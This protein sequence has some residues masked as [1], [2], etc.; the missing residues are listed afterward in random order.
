MTATIDSSNDSSN[1]GGAPE[2]LQQAAQWFAVMQSESVTEQE[3]KA[4]Q[5]W[6]SS[7]EQH[8]QAWQKVES[9]SHRFI[10][11]PVAASRAALDSSA[12]SAITRRQAL[13]TFAF[14]F[15]SSGIVWQVARQRHWDAQYRTARGEIRQLD[16]D[17]GSRL[18]LNTASAVD[19][20]FSPTLRQ[21]V[22][23]SGELYI[24][25]A[26][27]TRKRKRPLVVD[28]RFGR[29]QALGTRF[30]V[31]QGEDRTLLSVMQAAVEIRL[32]HN[33]SNVHPQVKRVKSGQQVSFNANTLQP[34]VSLASS[35]SA[36]IKGVIVADNMRLD[37]FINE[38]NRY[39]KGH[40]G[41]HPAVAGLR[42][43]GAYPVNDVER[44]LAALEQS[45]PVTI[46]RILPWWVTIKVRED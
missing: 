7:S 13:K 26:A 35:S 10:D 17:D 16:L 42:L 15:V 23:H 33:A 20:T 6:L 25:T 44:I 46:H 43:V 4:W 12:K 8:H 40:L 32:K 31:R 5:H 36:W 41:Y 45:H 28:T 21:I 22:L 24:E 34:V 30:N 27:D 37:D 38:L 3:R 1:N 39:H 29:L 14:F 2:L 11:L 19:V 18:W 9:I